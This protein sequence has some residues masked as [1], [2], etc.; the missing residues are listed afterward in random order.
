LKKYNGVEEDE[1]FV[2]VRGKQRRV[3]VDKFVSHVEHY[4]VFNI[5]SF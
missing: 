3:G 4:S 5:L 1:A 2:Q